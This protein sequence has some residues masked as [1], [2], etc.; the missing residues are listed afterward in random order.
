M[1]QPGD[2]SGGRR[3]EEEKKAVI[4][5]GVVMNKMLRGEQKLKR[6]GKSKK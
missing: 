4:E 2:M 3:G 1:R 6:K 5:Q